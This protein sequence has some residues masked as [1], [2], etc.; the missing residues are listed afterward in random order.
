MN[1]IIILSILALLLSCSFLFKENGLAKSSN[2]LSN[3]PNQKFMS[4]TVWLNR[5]DSSSMMVYDYDSIQNNKI[6]KSI[7]YYEK[8]DIYDKGKPVFKLK[9]ELY[10]FDTG[11]LR[12]FF[13]TKDIR[14]NRKTHTVEYDMDKVILDEK[15]NYINSLTLIH[16]FQV[17][18]HLYKSDEDNMLYDLTK[19]GYDGIPVFDYNNPSPI[20]MKS[21][22]N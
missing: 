22:K 7:L 21:I 14:I 19:N 17:Y 5:E 3:K 12:S 6:L 20:D 8:M 9:Q 1:R 10:F 15:D 11:K 2:I 4:D 16:D 13:N 18:L